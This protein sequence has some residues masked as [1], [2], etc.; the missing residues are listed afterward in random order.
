MK[1]RKC[2]QCG[3]FNI[4]PDLGGIT[5]KFVCRNCGYVGVLFVEQ[6][7][8]EKILRKKIKKL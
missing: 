2:P 4:V 6:T 5:G 8:D 3:S 7:I 1:L